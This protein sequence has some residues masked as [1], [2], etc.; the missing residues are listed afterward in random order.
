MKIADIATTLYKV[1]AIA[2]ILYKFSI[3]TSSYSKKISG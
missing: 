3:E 1:S 2:Y